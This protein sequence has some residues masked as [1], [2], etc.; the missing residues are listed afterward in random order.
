[1]VHEAF[2]SVE[3]GLLSEADFQAFVFTNPAT[4][5]A[6]S[7]P[8]FFAGTRVETAVSTLSSD[9]TT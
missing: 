4:L 9:A 2:E 1:M 3:R 7:N 8:D 5:W 6:S